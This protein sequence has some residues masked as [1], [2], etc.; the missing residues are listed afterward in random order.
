MRLGDRLDPD[1]LQ[2]GDGELAAQPLRILQ[3]EGQ[4]RRIHRGALEVG[5][6]GLDGAHEESEELDLARVAEHVHQH[7]PARL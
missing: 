2:S 4:R 5:A 7:P 6:D 3:L 1:V